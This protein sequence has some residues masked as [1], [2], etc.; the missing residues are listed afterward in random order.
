ML[1]WIIIAFAFVWMIVLPFGYANSQDLQTIPDTK[2]VVDQTSTLTAAQVETL[3][4]KLKR[5]REANDIVI[6]VLIVPTTQ[7]EDIFQYAQRTFDTWKLGNK[8]S[9]NGLLIILAKNDRKIRIHTGYG[10]ENT[11]T[12]AKA[13]QI[14]SNQMAPKFKAG[15]FYGGFNA[16]VDEI[17]RQTKKVPVYAPPPATTSS[18]GLSPAAWFGIIIVLLF[19]VALGI[20]M[21]VH[22]KRKRKAEEEERYQRMERER[23]AFN[24]SFERSLYNKPTSRPSRPSRPEPQR[25]QRRETRREREDDTPA[26]V[27][28]PIVV[29]SKRSRSSD[30]SSSSS[31]SD[32]S[33]SSSDSGGSSGGGGSSGDY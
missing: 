27:V 2:R 16:A 29:E 23:E 31:S 18:E 33:W 25:S 19:T 20:S 17:E 10:V 32:N 26:V 14:I 1:R 22:A 4:T 28:V 5:V 8:V 6:G 12:D 3:A 7:P 11:I 9:D 24:R 15:D 21:Y 13:K 30:Y